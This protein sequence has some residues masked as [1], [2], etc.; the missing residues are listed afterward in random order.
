MSFVKNFKLL[1]FG[2]IVSKVLGTLLYPILTRSYST[3]SFANYSLISSVVTIGYPFFTYY[4]QLAIPLEKDEKDIARIL[5]FI[6]INTFIISAI[7]LLFIHFIPLDTIFGYNFSNLKDYLLIILFSLF[8]MAFTEVLYNIGT[9]VGDFKPVIYSKVFQSLF[10]FIIS[11]ILIEK[12]NNSDGLI[13]GM[14][15]QYLGS[16]II[17]IILYGNFIKSLNLFVNWQGVF[18]TLSRNMEYPFYRFPYELISKFILYFPV[19][20][21][22]YFYDKDSTGQIGLAIMI[23]GAPIALIGTSIGR[24]YYSELSNPDNSVERI[25]YYTKKVF[26]SVIK[27]GVVPSIV[28]MLAS[29]YLFNFI[30]GSDWILVGEYFSILVPLSLIKLAVLPISGV[31]NYFNRQKILFLVSFIN[32]ILIILLTF[33]HLIWPLS[34]IV[35]LISYSIIVSFCYLYIYYYTIMKLL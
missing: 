10:F 16:V 22:Y 24:A 15:L 35:F 9:R 30:F 32:I 33:F 25:K 19:I 5:F 26:N 28:L 1:T 12:F 7:V 2:S 20:F 13:W 4:F 21:F 18:N 8:L 11:Y 27:F 31:F 29:Y 14:M 3:D 34:E 23:M 17:M 6:L